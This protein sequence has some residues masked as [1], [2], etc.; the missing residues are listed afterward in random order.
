M[1]NK[2]IAIVSIYDLN[3]YGNRLQNIAVYKL[4]KKNNYEPEVIE[5]D[6]IGRKE[7]FVRPIKKVLE[8][9]KISTKDIRYRLFLDFNKHIKLSKYKILWKLNREIVDKKMYKDY[10]CFLVGSDQVWNPEFAGFGFYFLDFVKDNKKKIAFSASIGVTDVSDE[11]ANK[12]QLNL[13]S[14]NAISVREQQA[15]DLITSLTKRDDVVTL[16][17]PTMM[18]EPEEWDKLA[19]KPKYCKGERF[20]LNYFLGEQSPERRKII[21]DFAKKMGYK[22]INILDKE[23]PFYASGPAEFLWLEKNAELICTDSFHSSV[24]G[25]LFNTPF[26]V[27]DREDTS[28]NMSSRLDNLLRLFEL[29]DRKFIGKELSESYLEIDYSSAYEKLLSE[30]KKGLNFLINAI[31]GNKKHEV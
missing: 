15:N 7:Y 3:N 29:N 13:S 24:F 1:K 22:V 5:V 6:Y 26:L 28:K 30:K 31:E 10:D 20:I 27:F 12:M 21:N 9:C 2:K 18:L 16:V 14:F 11:Y 8:F 25:I 17:D 23:N 4:L 19:R